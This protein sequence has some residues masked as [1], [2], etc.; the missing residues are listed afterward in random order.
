MTDINVGTK[1]RM[2]FGPKGTDG[3]ITKVESK[4]VFIEWEEDYEGNPFSQ[5][6]SKSDLGQAPRSSIGVGIFPYE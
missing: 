5:W 3:T 1:M 4:R 2:A 6:H